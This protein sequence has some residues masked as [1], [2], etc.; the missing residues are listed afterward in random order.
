MRW[1]RTT[2][3]AGLAPG[4]DGPTPHDVDQLS[5]ADPSLWAHNSRCAVVPGGYFRRHITPAAA[6]PPFGPRFDCGRIPTVIDHTNTPPVRAPTMLAVWSDCSAVKP[7]RRIWSIF[8][9]PFVQPVLNVLPAPCNTVGGNPGWKWKLPCS[10]QSPNRS[11]REA[12]E[13]VNSTWG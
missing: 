7:C 10:D 2:I 11:T 9:K 1:Q 5:G 6:L 4:R 13:F 3:P 12:G 8:R